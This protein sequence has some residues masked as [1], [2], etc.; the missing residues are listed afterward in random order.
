MAALARA[1]VPAA[2]CSSASRRRTARR[3]ATARHGRRGVGRPDRPPRRPRRTRSR[4]SGASSGSS[5]TSGPSSSARPTSSSAT[6]PARPARPRARR[7]R[8]GDRRVPRPRGRHRGPRGDRARRPRPGRPARAAAAVTRYQARP[9]AVGAADR[10]S[11][12]RPT[13]RPAAAPSSCSATDP[14][15][16]L[17]RIAAPDRRRSSP[18]S[19]PEREAVR[20]A[21]EETRR[22]EPLPADGPPWVVLLARQGGAEGRT[23]IAVARGVAGR[24][25]ASSCRAPRVDAP[26]HGQSLE[27]RIVAATPVRRRTA[28][29]S[30]GDSPSSSA[31]SSP[32]PDRSSSRA[33]DPPRR[34]TPG[35]PS[36]RSSAARPAAAVARA[37]GCPAYRLLGNLH[38]L[39]DGPRQAR[40]LL[41]PLSRPARRPRERL[42]TL[43]A[44]LGDAGPGRGGRQPRRPPQHGRVPGRRIEAVDRLG[45]RGPELRLALALALRLVQDAQD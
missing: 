17:E 45:P 12:R 22:A 32:S 26:R 16:E 7:P 21:R 39:P 33:S 35:R 8:G 6:W 24:P 4:S 30:P 18:S 44:V 38:N 2:S 40:A 36:K 15:S 42:A 27:L 19:W 14:A 23:T 25:C 41:A 11:R 31:G 34:P 28:S 10:R 43:R 29:R 37:A 20:Q 9:S 13:R 3:R 1:R 5:S